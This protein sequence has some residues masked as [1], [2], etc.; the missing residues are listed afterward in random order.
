MNMTFIKN[1]VKRLISKDTSLHAGNLTYLA[2][3]SLIPTLIIAAT[4]L[5]FLS[6][7]FPL[8]EYPSFGKINSILAKLTLKKTSSLLINII[9][10]NLLSSGIYS[11]ITTIECIYHFKFKNYIRK[12][13]YSI[14]LSIIIITLII[15]SFS[16]SLTI[17][18]FSSLK[19]IDLIISAIITFISILTFYKFATFQKL[20]SIY[21]GALLSSFILAIF[22]KFFNYIVENFSK[23][24]LYYGILTPIIIFILL[25]YYSCYIIYAGIIFNHELAKIYGIKHEK[26]LKIITG[27]ITNAYNSK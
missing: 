20:K 12:K 16:L 5:S 18:K 23:L 22:Y 24:Q 21:P 14:A 26:K 27:K 9:C 17:L 25:I 7:N 19:K 6:K 8:L 15:I 1:F 11:L 4:I 10:I 2:L 3:I 13:L